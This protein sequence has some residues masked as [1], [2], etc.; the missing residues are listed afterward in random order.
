VHH[1][2]DPIALLEQRGE[3]EQSVVLPTPCVPMKA[4]FTPPHDVIPSAARDLTA[5][6]ILSEAKDLSLGMGGILRR[7][8]PQDGRI[9]AV[10]TT[11]LVA[12]SA[13]CPRR[14]RSSE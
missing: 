4:N 3:L 5:A 7:S 10:S 14:W 9:S 1:L 8:A 6:V 12:L 2:D 13:R 11:A